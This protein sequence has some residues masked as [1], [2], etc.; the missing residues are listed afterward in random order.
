MACVSDKVMNLQ[1]VMSHLNFNWFF[2]EPAAFSAA[3]FFD[4][5]CKTTTSVPFRQNFFYF[6]STFFNDE[7]VYKVLKTSYLKS[8]YFSKAERKDTG[9]RCYPPNVFENFFL[10]IL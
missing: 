1:T 2:K 9:N 6:F 7:N 3:P 8:S 10:K 4:W 5:E